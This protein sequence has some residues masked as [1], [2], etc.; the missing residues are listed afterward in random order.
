MLVAIL[1]LVLAIAT[2]LLYVF[3]GTLPT[4]LTGVLA[5]AGVFLGALVAWIAVSLL[6]L[7]IVMVG[8]RDANPKRMFKHRVM[9]AFAEYYYCLILR[10]RLIVTGRENL[11]NHNLFVIYS[12]HIEAS[13]PMYLKM[14]FRRFPVAFISK[15]VLF[16]PV[17]RRRH[18]PLRRLHPD[19]ARGRPFGDEHDPRRHQARQGR[20]ALRAS[21]RKAAGPIRTISPRSSPDPS[22]WRRKRTRTSFRWPSTTCMKSTGKAASCPVRCVCTSFPRLLPPTMPESIR[23]NSRNASKRS[24]ARKWTSSSGSIRR[25]PASHEPT[26]CR[27]SAWRFSYR[28][29]SKRMIQ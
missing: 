28:K 21:T 12:N 7:I 20:T 6:F 2:T 9:I 16:K 26:A 5:V 8:F 29:K 25:R 17:P 23:S 22:S 3:F 11:P 13:D 18:A 27:F 14:V 4:G 15:E 10:V 24:S 19:F 1:H